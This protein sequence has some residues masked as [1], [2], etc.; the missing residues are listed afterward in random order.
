MDVGRAK[1][2]FQLVRNPR[3]LGLTK[4]HE[5]HPPLISPTSKGGEL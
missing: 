5:N 4:G 1:A 2:S 3:Q